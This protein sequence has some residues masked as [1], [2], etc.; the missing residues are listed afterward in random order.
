MGTTIRLA[1]NSLLGFYGVCMFKEMVSLDVTS[2]LVKG[3]AGNSLEY[4]SSG[5]DHAP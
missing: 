4:L 2:C 3:L 1:P 5:G